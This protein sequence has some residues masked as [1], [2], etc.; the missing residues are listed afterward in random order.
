MKKKGLIREIEDEINKKLDANKQI[1]QNKR[2][3]TLRLEST[4]THTALAYRPA[5]RQA[6]TDYTR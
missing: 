5:T 6:S 2:H 3:L 4:N 1:L